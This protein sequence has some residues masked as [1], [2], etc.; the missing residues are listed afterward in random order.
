MSEAIQINHAYTD[1]QM[2]IGHSF[3]P[4]KSIQGFT[5]NRPIKQDLAL[6][7]Q[8]C[9]LET[10]VLG[11]PDSYDDTDTENLPLTHHFAPDVYGRE[12]LLPVGNVVVGKLHR[13]AHLNVILKGKVRVTTEEGV[14]EYTAPCIFTS[15]SGT[16]RAVYV[17]EETIWL[18]V[19]PTE[20]TDLKKI[21][22]YVIAKTY[23]DL[24]R[25]ESK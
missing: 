10:A 22:D 16:K 18:T 2:G 4:I 7:K 14:K 20:Q 17:L 9:D 23:D 12:M 5:D 8:I 11:L 1:V 13:H 6:R 15:F 3:S 21:E 19:H 24:N 25:I